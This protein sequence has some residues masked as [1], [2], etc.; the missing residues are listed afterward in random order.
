VIFNTLT[1]F[2]LPGAGKGAVTIVSVIVIVYTFHKI[3]PN[4]L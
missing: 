1:T 3:T 2:P 4:K